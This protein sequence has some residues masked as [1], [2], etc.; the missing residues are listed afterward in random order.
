MFIYMYISF[1]VITSHLSPQSPRYLKICHYFCRYYPCNNVGLPAPILSQAFRQCILDCRFL[2][3]PQGH[4]L[5]WRGRLLTLVAIV[6]VTRVLPLERP[7]L[8][9]LESTNHMHSSDTDLHWETQA[10]YQSCQNISFY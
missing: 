1:F 10:P 5:Q 6:E 9:L 2:P 3:T 8:P 7:R 4:G